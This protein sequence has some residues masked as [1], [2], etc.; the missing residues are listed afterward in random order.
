MDRNKKYLEL[1]GVNDENRRRSRQRLLKLDTYGYSYWMEKDFEWEEDYV[2]CDK[3]DLNLYLEEAVIKKHVKYGTVYLFDNYMIVV[4]DY[5]GVY[6][7]KTF[8]G[9][10]KYYKNLK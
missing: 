3:R 10:Y 4:G 7:K 1:V 2:V 8:E 6:T 9:L 5:D